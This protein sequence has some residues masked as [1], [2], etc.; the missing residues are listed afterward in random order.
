MNKE[1]ILANSLIGTNIS[2]I[3]TINFPKFILRKQ[4]VSGTEIINPWTNFT[5]FFNYDFN[6]IILGVSY[7]LP[8]KYIMTL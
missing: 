1:I 3:N 8:N 4:F 6:R 5:L 7:T 2:N